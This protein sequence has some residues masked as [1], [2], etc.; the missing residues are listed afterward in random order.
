MS[1]THRSGSDSHLKPRAL[2]RMRQ[3]TVTRETRDLNAGWAEVFS[4]AREIQE[5]VPLIAR[6]FGGDVAASQRQ[7]AAVASDN[8]S[9]IDFD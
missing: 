8:T 3:C 2:K 9:D 6:A 7:L 4:Q 5:C 1:K